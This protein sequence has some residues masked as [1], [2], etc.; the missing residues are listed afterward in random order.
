MTS[1]SSTSVDYEFTVRVLTDAVQKRHIQITISQDHAEKF[2]KNILGA[3]AATTIISDFAKKVAATAA[4][5]TD[6]KVTTPTTTKSVQPTEEKKD[7]ADFDLESY[8][9]KIMWLRSLSDDDFEDTSTNAMNE[10]IASI[11]AADDVSEKNN[12]STAIKTSS[13]LFAKR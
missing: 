3:D 12:A 4:A 9:H 1:A 8:R 2:V 13:S 11:L 5:A 6:I 7:F 10:E